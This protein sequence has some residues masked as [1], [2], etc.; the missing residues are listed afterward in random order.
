MTNAKDF[1]NHFMLEIKNITFE[2]LLRQD[3]RF[4]I[5]MVNKI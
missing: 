4:I 3:E 1:I 2:D 5:D